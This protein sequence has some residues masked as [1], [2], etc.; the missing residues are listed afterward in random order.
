MAS[1]LQHHFCLTGVPVAA[2]ADAKDSGIHS[3][4]GSVQ[5]RLT[6]ESSL[7]QLAEQER[8]IGVLQSCRGLSGIGLAVGASLAATV[9]GVA[10]GR[11]PSIGIEGSAGLIGVGLSG[12]SLSGILIAR[13][14]KTAQYVYDDEVC[15]V[16]PSS[17]D[18]VARR[19]Q[20]AHAA[21]RRLA[22][23]DRTIRKS[24]GTANLLLGAAVFVVS[25]DALV[26][27]KEVGAVGLIMAPIIA[28]GGLAAL[29][30]STE[31]EKAY[32]LLGQGSE[33]R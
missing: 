30:Q 6:A 15:R 33:K 1:I 11:D 28:C 7:H 22:S 19:E 2:F 27:E 16:D 17:P 13:G 24:V 12:L 9:G 25:M 32:E 3:D 23:R 21:L 18:G 14:S 4:S 29:E 8:K 26:H 5:Q 31:Y 20:L 10:L